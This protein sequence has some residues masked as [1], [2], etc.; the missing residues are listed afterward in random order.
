VVPVRSLKLPCTALRA[1]SHS[2]NTLCEILPQVREKKYEN[3]FLEDSGKNRRH[4]KFIQHENINNK[5]AEY[6]IKQSFKL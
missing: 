1:T 2:C 3:N 5:E 4:L 6:Y